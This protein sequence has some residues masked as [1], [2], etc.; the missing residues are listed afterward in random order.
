MDTIEV[1][2]EKSMEKLSFE[3]TKEQLID[4]FKVVVADAE[5]LLKATANQGGEKLAEVR[6]KAEESLRVA[7]DKMAEAQ[8]ALLVKTKAAAKATDVYVHENPWRAVGVAAGVGL[9]IGLLIGRR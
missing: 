7:K 2:T 3:V 5:A 4:D 8:A 9:V 1:A 6:A